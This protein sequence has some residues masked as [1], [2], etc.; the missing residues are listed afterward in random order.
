M[1]LRSVAKTLNASKYLSVPR[2]SQAFPRWQFRVTGAGPWAVTC[3]VSLLGSVLFSSQGM[4][5]PDLSFPVEASLE[6]AEPRI[7]TA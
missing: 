1:L 2:I 6:T 7:E 5:P 3:L 4:N